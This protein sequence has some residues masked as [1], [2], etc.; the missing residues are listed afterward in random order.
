MS[1]AAFEKQ[2]VREALDLIAQRIEAATR[3]ARNLLAVRGT[4]MTSEGYLALVSLA[5]QLEQ[6]CDDA[7]ADHASGL[8]CDVVEEMQKRRFEVAS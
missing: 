8:M 7:R 2:D 1:T 3:E 6:L 5:S 4:L